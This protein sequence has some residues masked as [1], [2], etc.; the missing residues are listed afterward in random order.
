MQ[1]ANNFKQVGLA[2]HNYNSSA[3]SFPIGID[4]QGWWSWGAR[5]LPFIEQQAVFD[6]IDFKQPNWYWEPS[7]NR[8]AAKTWVSAFLCP[9]DPQATGGPSEW[10]G[11]SSATPDEGAGMSNML[12]VADTEPNSDNF[13]AWY[14][15]SSPIGLSPHFYSAEVNG[16]FGGGGACN[17]SDI[18]DGTSN[19]LAIGEVTGRGVGT[20]QGLF[21]AGANSGTTADGI[22]GVSTVVGGIWGGT[23]GNMYFV[24]FASW[25]PGGCNFV[26]AD[27]SVAFLSQNIDQNTLRAL[28]TRNGCGRVT[29][30]TEKVISGPP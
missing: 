14:P 5:V 28:T 26:L 8:A 1:C 15:P 19:T 12:S 10:I 30:W 27:G 18:K 29:T 3:G 4:Y 7:Q 20:H 22:N 25:H 2:L 17:T 11:I 13:G 23:A 6:M 21:W 16:M 24:G 9:T